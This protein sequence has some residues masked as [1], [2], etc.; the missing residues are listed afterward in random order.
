MSDELIVLLGGRRAGMLTRG[1]FAYDDSYR[2][3]PT[4][5]PLSLSM[6]VADR[7]HPG[8]VVRAFCEGLLPDNDRVLERWGRDFHVSA[9]NPFALLR[10]VGE[11][12]AG[13][14]QFVRPERVDMLLARQGTVDPLSEGQ[15]AERIRALRRDPS[16]WHLASAGQFSLA[17]AQAKTA[18]Y[19]DRSTGMWGDPS[20]ATPTTHPQ[21]GDRRLRRP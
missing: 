10:H 12:C 21:T 9:G 16:A 3:L 11:D 1:A 19:L 2:A 17:G 13:A 6:P 5:I 20:G 18:L 14:V 4:A 15:L 7:T 8:V